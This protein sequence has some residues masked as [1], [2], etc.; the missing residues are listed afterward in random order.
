MI[1]AVDTQSTEAFPESDYN[2]AVP[3]EIAAAA[4]EEDE[5]EIPDPLLPPRCRF[6]LTPEQRQNTTLYSAM[7]QLENHNRAQE[8]AIT[9]FW[10]T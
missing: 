5:T 7:N 9:Q 10:N 4:E 8:D 2:I 6:S 3:P 1:V